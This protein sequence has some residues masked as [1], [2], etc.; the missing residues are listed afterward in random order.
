MIRLLSLKNTFLLFLFSLGAC[1]LFKGESQT[2]EMALNIPQASAPVPAAQDLA[3]YLPRLKGK[4]IA[5][6][7]NQTS[8]LG[9]DNGTYTHLV[10]TLLDHGISISKVFAPEHGFRGQADAGET[11][12][13]GVDKQTGLSVISLYGK[14]K[15]PSADQLEELDLVVFDIQDVGVRFYTYISTLHYVMEACAEKGIP[16]MVL[17]RPNPNGSYIDGPT[18]ES[19][20]QSFLGM[21][22]IPLVH[23]MTIAEY[24]QM[25]NGEGWLSDNLTCELEIV[26]MK[27]YQREM[28]YSLPIRP[29]PNLPN[30][31]SIV[32]YPSLGL[33]EGTHINAGRG[34]EF[35]FQRFGA[36]FLDQ[37][38]F[39]F[40]YTPQPNF[41]AKD[42]KHNGALCYGKDLSSEPAPGKVD[43]QWIIEA[44]QNTADKTKFFKDRSFTLHAGTEKV[45]EQIE[46]G[47][48]ASE[49]R[50]TWKD[51]LERFKEMRKAYLIYP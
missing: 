35:Q 42:P 6:V 7:A 36:P 45:R 13:D 26:Q 2:A 33:F 9:N 40:S 23:G 31:Q 8:V 28:T 32:L 47:M 16:V 14:N 1:S 37:N 25:I 19:E 18:L 43:L 48:T 3:A 10:D 39:G 11:V 20:H 4:T 17:D 5:V 41:G 22:P 29:S 24:A 50:A 49:I 12:K 21:H 38:H 15:K 51:D 44:Y 46:K 27:G 34:T 30:D